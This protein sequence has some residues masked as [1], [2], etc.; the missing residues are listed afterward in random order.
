M[1]L[2]IQIIHNQVY[3]KYAFGISRRNWDIHTSVVVL[4]YHPK[5]FY[6]AA[7]AKLKYGLSWRNIKKNASIH[8]WIKLDHFLMHV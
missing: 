3:K 8:I 4:L 2:H 6:Y 5:I 7:V 1:F